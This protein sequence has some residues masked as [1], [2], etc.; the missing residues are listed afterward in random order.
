MGS[1]CRLALNQS[2]KFGD[3]DARADTNSQIAG[4]IVLHFLQAIHEQN[5]VNPRRNTPDVLVNK[6]SCRHDCKFVLMSKT[7]DRRD[8]LH[9]T[10]SNHHGGNDMI[11]RNPAEVF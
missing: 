2:I 10:G 1:S 4:I 7:E 6:A 5:D 11:D 8:L 9:R 3:G